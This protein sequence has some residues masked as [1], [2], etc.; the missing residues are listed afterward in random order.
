MN[1]LIVET[2]AS[3][4]RSLFQSVTTVMGN[5]S[6]LQSR[7]VHGKSQTRGK[8]CEEPRWQSDGSKGGNPDEQSRN[9]SQDDP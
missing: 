9:N 6:H 5:L 7:E 8:Q 1:Q 2:T 3:A 4:I